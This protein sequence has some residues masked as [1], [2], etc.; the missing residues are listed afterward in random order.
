MHILSQ[1]RR[2]LSPVILLSLLFAV[3]LLPLSIVKGQ[4]TSVT[5]PDLTGMNVP[6]AAAALNR[7]GLILGAQTS[8]PWTEASGIPSN[9]ISAQSA[10]PGTVLP[11]GTE[12]NVN[13]LRPT[14][15]TLIYDDNDFTLL[16]HTGSD[17]NLRELV[18]NAVEGTNTATFEARRWTS[19]VGQNLCVQLW[20][21]TRYD[22]KATDG[23]ERIQNW[24]V[25]SRNT[26]E[27]FWTGANGIT[28]FNVVQNGVERATCPAAAVGADETL[29]EVFFPTDVNDEATP[30]VY[31]AYTPHELIILNP[32]QDQW[33]P[34]EGVQ[35]LNNMPDVAG[36]T[37][38]FADP[39]VF[40]NPETFGVINRLAPG[41]CLLYT[42]NDPA[43]TNT[44]KPCDVI[45]HRDLTPNVVFWSMAFGLDSVTNDEAQSCPPATEGHVTL[46]IMP[47]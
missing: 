1:S 15:V 30:F 43:S 46:C 11:A 4:E 3:G 25:S 37:F 42:N 16:N 13:V 29:C 9:T 14:N 21:V 2:G 31:F 38:A 33:M 27:H 10:F 36:T 40:D 22:A 23:C 19:S 18:F 12:V 20:S 39:A 34:L 47:R 35:I 5:A 41:Q 28:R 26:A 45:A 7:V 8:I 44:P 17:L 24:L 32:S 6:Q